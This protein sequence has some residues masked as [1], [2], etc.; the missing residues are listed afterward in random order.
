MTDGDHTSRSASYSP[1]MLLRPS[2]F[3]LY[4]IYLF[5]TARAGAHNLRLGGPVPVHCGPTDSCQPRHDQE[6]SAGASVKKIEALFVH[7]L[8]LAREIGVSKRWGRWRSNGTKNKLRRTPADKQCGSL[9]EHADKIEAQLEAKLADLM[10]EAKAADE[11]NLPDEHINTATSW[12]APARDS[13]VAQA[14]PK[15]RRRIKAP[16]QETP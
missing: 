11:T 2:S 1:P 14:E 13:A 16:G 9:Y 3:R 12:L 7:V 6:P 15:H 4:N 8:L 10:A 5:Q